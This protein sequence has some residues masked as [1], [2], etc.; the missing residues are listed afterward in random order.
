LRRDDGKI[1]L[2]RVRLDTQ[3]WP[4]APTTVGDLVAHAKGIV[5]ETYEISIQ[6]AKLTAGDDN[7]FVLGG[8]QEVAVS[9]LP[10]RKGDVS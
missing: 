4:I 2:Q 8:E 5:Q 7:A 1:E 3:N 10:V 9:A 6:L